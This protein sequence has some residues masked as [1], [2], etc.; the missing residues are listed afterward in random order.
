[1]WASGAYGYLSDYL[2]WWIVPLSLIVHTWCF[3]H[4]FPSQKR[5]RLRLIVGNLLVFMTALSLAGLI[6]ESY[7]RFLVVET[8]SYGASLVSKRWFLLYPQTN[9]IY[10]RDKEWIEGRR[11]GVHRIA[12][13]GDSFTYGWGI[14]DSQDRFTEIIQ[15]RFDAQAPG[16]YEVMNVAWS[17]WG[18]FDHIGAVHDMIQD[19]AVDEI[20]LVHVPNDIES[21][22]PVTAD[23]DPKLP[24]RSRY[25]NVDHS[26][27]LNYLFHR[28]LAPRTRQVSTYWDW[29]AKGYADKAIW[30]RQE[31]QF[32]R[33]LSLCEAS[34][35]RIRVVLFPF[36]FTSGG[37][38]Q[39]DRVQ[40]QV[41]AYFAAKSVPTLDLYPQISAEDPR[42]M[43]VNSHD[44]HPNERANRLVA[45]AIWKAFFADKRN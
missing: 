18:T 38:F 13:I 36:L 11:P 6:G 23:Y 10:C 17:G 25:I 34:G 28:V 20:V 19:Y 37:Q 32:D 12:F 3:F 8:D 33:I 41:A 21:L 7:F 39:S 15:A 24:P 16:Q 27:L 2:W 35:T 42:M 5:P 40:A 22:L 44:P 43:M 9:S 29:L 31:A 26:Y 14:N 45:E 30:S 1:M 4:F